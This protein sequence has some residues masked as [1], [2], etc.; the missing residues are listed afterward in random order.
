MLAAALGAMLSVFGCEKEEGRKPRGPSESQ[1]KSARADE[2][3]ERVIKSRDGAEMVYVPDGV[4]I[5]GADKGRAIEGPRMKVFLEGFYIDRVEVSAVNFHKFLEDT[6]YKPEGGFSYAPENKHLPARQLT[7]QD[8][9][10]YCEW[11]GKR[12]PT[13]Y[14]WEKAA[15]GPGGLK[16]PWGDEPKE[17]PATGPEKPPL[18]RVY[19]DPAGQSPYGCLNMA[20]NVWE[21]SDDWLTAYVLNRQ[22]DKRFGKKYK[23]LRGGLERG[24][25]SHS[26][27]PSTRRNYL[28]P[29]TASELTGARCAMY[30]PGD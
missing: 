9:A 24:E 16:W 29:G 7:W 28:P 11:V 23:V 15:R 10:K 13:E 5:M 19:A 8:A 30:P 14:E 27:S 17:P 22:D 12:L 26:Y 1:E 21:W 25:G 20:G 4:F 6:G 18:I 2:E 3:P